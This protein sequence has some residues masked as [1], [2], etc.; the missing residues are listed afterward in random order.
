MGAVWSCCNR[1][2]ASWIVALEWE[3]EEIDHSQTFGYAS[4]HFAIED[5]QPKKERVKTIEISLST[6]PG[7]P[8]GFF[9]RGTRL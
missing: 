4:M 7:Q 1:R 9:F 5:E 3:N 6:L 8:P 2:R